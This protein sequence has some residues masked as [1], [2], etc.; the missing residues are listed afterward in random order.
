M[1]DY[2]KSFKTLTEVI[3]RFQQKKRNVTNTLQ[4]FQSISLC[5]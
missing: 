4:G 1:I 5:P 3:V 2:N